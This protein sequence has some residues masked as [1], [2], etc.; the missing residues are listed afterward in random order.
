MSTKISLGLAS[1][2]VAS[3]SAL[4][5]PAVAIRSV[6]FQLFTGSRSLF[7]CRFASAV[8][9]SPKRATEHQ[10]QWDNGLVIRRGELTQHAHTIAAV[11]LAVAA[12]SA[13]AWAGPADPVNPLTKR[14]VQG[15]ALDICDQGGLFIGGVPKVT[16]YLNSATA[17]GNIR[18]ALTRPEFRPR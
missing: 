14:F 18:V 9:S 4:I 17:A 13:S 12:A 1:Y 2:G 10:L 3:Y 15:K 8:R 16:N 6:E 5:F 11:M 7:F